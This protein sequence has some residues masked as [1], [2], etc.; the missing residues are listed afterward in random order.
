MRTRTGCVEISVDRSLAN[1][2]EYLV[3]GTWTDKQSWERAHQNN[4]QFKSLFSSLTIER[5]TLSLASFFE[6]ANAFAGAASGE[7]ST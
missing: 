3:L 2:L 7:R 4:D 5:H 1:P 6:P